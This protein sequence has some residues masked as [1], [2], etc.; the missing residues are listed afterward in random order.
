MPSAEEAKAAM[1]G[2]N[3]REIAGRRI[4]CNE[5]RPREDRPSGGGGGG[6]RGGGGGGG[7]RGGHGGGGH[8]GGRGGDRVDAA[9]EVI[10]AIANR[11]DIEILRTDPLDH[12]CS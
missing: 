10:A 1:D 3:Q 7:Y 6:Y 5:A 11:E 9:T 12:D 4:S 2:L 8:G